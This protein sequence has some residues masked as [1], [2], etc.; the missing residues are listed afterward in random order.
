MIDDEE[1][2]QSFRR[3]LQRAAIDA[4]AAPALPCPFQHVGAPAARHGG[5]YLCE[6]CW[7]AMTDEVLPAVSS[8]A[9]MAMA[10]CGCD[11]QGCET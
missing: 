1:F 2:F 5:R 4:A 8:P 9:G 11:Q 6:F 7:D 3:A 10:W